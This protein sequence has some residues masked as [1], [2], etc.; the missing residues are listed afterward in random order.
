M[1]LVGFLGHAITG[2]GK[3]VGD[4][5]QQSAGNRQHFGAQLCSG[6]CHRGTAH[7]PDA[8]G[9]GAHAKCN[10]I[11]LTMDDPDAVRGR[12]SASVVG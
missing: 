3:T 12:S 2:D 5:L 9:E 6:D 1:R 8:R 10:A 11:G 7:H 4:G